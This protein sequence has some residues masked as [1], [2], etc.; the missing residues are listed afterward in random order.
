MM[1]LSR[2]FESARYQYRLFS[3]V[4]GMAAVAGILTFLIAGCDDMVEP[5]APKPAFATQSLSDQRLVAGVPISPLTLPKASGGDGTLTYSLTPEVP[6]LTFSA[7]TR[8]LSG[9]PSAASTYSMRYEVKDADG[10]T[11]ALSFRIEAQPLTKL[12]WSTYTGIERASLSGMNRDDVLSQSEVSVPVSV[13]TTRSHVYW[14]ELVQRADATQEGKIRRADRDGTAV[15]LVSS[16]GLVLDLEIDGTNQKLYWTE[17]GNLTEE[18]TGKIGW[19]DLDGTDKGYILQRTDTLILSIALDVP[20]GK[21]YWTEIGLTSVGA[22]AGG[23]IRR[24]NFDGS[25]EEDLVTNVPLAP[26]EGGFAFV[27]GRLQIADGKMYYVTGNGTIAS[28]DVDGTG[29]QDI[30]TTDGVIF[31]IA[32]DAAGQAIYWTENPARVY[33]DTGTWISKIRRAGVDGTGDE[34][35]LTA[36][37]HLLVGV[38]LDVADRKIVWTQLSG[39]GG[40]PEATAKIRRANL[41]GST[42]QD[43]LVSEVVNIQPEAFALDAVGEKMYWLHVDRST[44]WLGRSDLNG[45]GVL[46]DPLDTAFV[47]PLDTFAF[48]GRVQGIALDVVNGKVY[49]AETVHSRPSQ[50]KIRRANFDGSGVMDVI[51]VAGQDHGHRSIDA[52]AVADDKVYWSV[53]EN[54]RRA[55]LDGSGEED[56]IVDASAEAIAMDA[57]SRKIYW[58]DSSS[59]FIQRANLDGSGKEDLVKVDSPYE[60]EIAVDAVGGKMYWATWATEGTGGT[61][62]IRR[63]NLDGSGEQV[64]L[65]EISGVN[66]IALGTR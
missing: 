13:E 2:S 35:V 43:F 24:A 36:S 7:D 39:R 25:G 9:I 15:D 34:D 56:F 33:G 52:L 50:S 21:M 41:D 59:K 45:S 49:W 51:V 17:I 27:F 57:V 26:T 28:A 38:S 18:P 11:D 1:N 8:T 42:Q 61:K 58:I 48:A 29:A 12:Y 20:G 54:I 32:L 40:E 62:T 65:T 31:E 4:T 53:G 14:T 5:K 16:L 37:G 64:V 3:N 19:A 22:P 47:D 23:K 55:D 10:D 60:A 30:L 66:S 6:G 46:F 63:A 44:L